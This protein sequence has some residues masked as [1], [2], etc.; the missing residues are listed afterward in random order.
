MRIILIISILISIGINTSGQTWMRPPFLETPQEEATFDDVVRAFE[1]WWDDRPYER[2]MGYKPFKRWEYLNHPRCYPDG[3]IEGTERFWLTFQQIVKDYET[4][5]EDFSKT[6]LSNWTPMGLTSWQNG[7]EG[8]NPGN[9]RI[10]TVTVDPDNSQ[11]IYVAAPSGG[12]WK[13]IDGGS[14]WNTTFDQMPHLGVSAIAIHPDSS[15]IVFVGTGD[16]D[17][18]DTK[19]TGI[20]KSN[21]AGNTWNA[22]GLNSTGWNSI[23][24]II[25]NPQNPSTM[26][27]STNN[28]IYR[29]ANGGQTWTSVYTLSRVTDLLYH[30]T[31]TTILYGSGDCFVKSNNG[32]NSFTKNLTLP[33]DTSRVEIAVTPANA[34]Y[35]YVLASNSSS[36]YGGVYCSTNSGVSFN[37]MSDSPNY[38]GYSWD[39]DDN[40]GQGW[41]DLAIAA[42]PVDA[43]EI[44][45]GGINVWK[46]TD[47][48]QTFSISSHWVYDDPQQYTHADIHYLGFSGNRLFCG[49]DGGVFY[50]DD[51]AENWNDISEGLGIMQIYRLASSPID[52]DFIAVGAQDNGSNRLQSGQWT[53]IF[54]ADGMQTLTHPT[55]INIFYFSYQGGGIMRTLDNGETV[56]YLQ[57]MDV[58]GSWIT[59]FDMVNSSPNIMYAGFEE[60][61]KSENGGVTWTPISS[62][63][64][65][66][67]S[68]SHLKVSQVNPS[69]IYATRLGTLYVTKSGGQTW[70]PVGIGYAGTITGITLSS[71]DPEE[72]WVAASSGTSDR[73]FYTNNA[74]SSFSNITGNL[75]GTGIRCIIHQANS[76]DALFVGTENSVFYKDTTMADWIPYMN[77]LPNVI[78]QHLEINPTNNMLRAGTYG[79]GVWE[80]PIPI[81]QGTQEYADYQSLIIYPNPSDGI[82]TIELPNTERIS[83]VQIFDI[84]GQIVHSFINDKKMVNI[85]MSTYVS[86]VYFVKVITADKQYIKRLLLHN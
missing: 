70:N 49:S 58:Y 33:N 32:G 81:T 19:A 67:N 43:N 40:A 52:P 69:Y 42:S 68:I 86:G 54:G 61:Y 14:N 60:V 4:H 29:S 55:N 65:S 59:P 17:A 41:Y 57:P 63:L 22:A 18:W 75:S 82:F 47:A 83:T 12:V 46:S 16:R 64:T 27:A 34:S 77:G 13:S 24:K 53:H 50:S 39:A 5:K 85:D 45:I 74:G 7:N 51:Y 3:K 62:N 31:D 44:Y 76:H 10:N 28:G 30:P 20:Y 72:L 11:V 2:S 36:S 9:G 8:Y 84:N 15:Q 1:K 38:L 48:G 25:F 6:D 56:E 78:V 35:V 80:T 26:F 73:V 37:L 79:R 21:D 23:N 71:S 66:G